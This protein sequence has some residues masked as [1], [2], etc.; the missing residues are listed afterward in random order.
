MARLDEDHTLVLLPA[1]CKNGEQ[2]RNWL[3][4]I[5]QDGSNEWT[6]PEF[7]VDIIKQPCCGTDDIFLVQPAAIGEDGL[8]TIGACPKIQSFAWDGQRFRRVLEKE[9]PVCHG[10]WIHPITTF[11]AQMLSPVRE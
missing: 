10:H 1:I 5:N 7:D 2:A 4:V 8:L 6:S 3:V 11:R 9:F